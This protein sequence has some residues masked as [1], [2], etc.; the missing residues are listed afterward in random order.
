MMRERTQIL[1]RPGVLLRG[2]AAAA[3][4]GGAALAQ[5]AP[6]ASNAISQQA[7]P[8]AAAAAWAAAKDDLNA[9]LYYP[10]TPNPGDPDP[11]LGGTLGPQRVNQRQNQG[12]GASNEVSEKVDPTK[13][14]I[15]FGEVGKANIAGFWR[16]I[17][18]P[19]P[20]YYAEG[21]ALP[22]KGQ[23]LKQFGFPYKPE[24]MA[25]LN[26]RYHG[27]T[28]N[29]PYGDPAA[30]CL[31]Q[32]MFHNY[33]G[34]GSPLEIT[35]TPGRVHIIFNRMSQT[36][37]IWTNGLLHPADFTPTSEGHSIGHW[38]GDT[39]VVDTVGVRNEVSFGYKMPH[40]S[41]VHFVERFRRL[42]AETL[43]IYVNID[44]PIALTTSV[45]TTLYYKLGPP[46]DQHA[47]DFCVENNRNNPDEDLIVKADLNP[48]KRYGY[49]LPLGANH[50]DVE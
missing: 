45:Q 5:G 16:Q 11:V 20:Y 49:D 27:E 23:I 35:Q 22:T 26:G 8:A 41:K 18:G 17:P 48:R 7:A 1:G 32:G 42:D 39:L 3:M 4:L 33:V 21:K 50:E 12:P 6:P 34:D 24:W 40:S 10:I 15:Y 44:D 46:R 43:A 19:K 9:P 31:P 2:A 47:E 13:P 36:R 29:L 28:V 37:R 25:T 14:S 30:S 38:E